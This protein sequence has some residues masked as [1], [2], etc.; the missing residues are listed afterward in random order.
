MKKFIA[1]ASVFA[2]SASAFASVEDDVLEVMENISKPGKN[3]KKL[4]KKKDYK[5]PD[6]KVNA[7]AVIKGYEAMRNI[8][9][10][11]KMFNDFNA[12]MFTELDAFKEVLKGNDF[13]AI[14]AGWEKVGAACKEC[15]SEYK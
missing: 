7:E 12:K 9:H 13:D 3:I 1:I 5:N 10:E 2:L 14:K 8:K 4:V 15:H 11:E 6:F